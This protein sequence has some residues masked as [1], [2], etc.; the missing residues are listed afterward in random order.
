M[1]RTRSQQAR[2][3]FREWSRDSGFLVRM[4]DQGRPT[5]LDP[6]AFG[7]R[8]RDRTW[9]LFA[10]DLIS[11][12]SPQFQ[13]LEVTPTLEA[14]LDQIH[15]DLRPGGTI[16]SVPLRSPVTRKVVGGLVVRPRFGWNDIGPLLQEIGW[17]AS[18][19]LLSFPLV[20]GAAK[21]V[22]PWVLAGPI[23]ERFCA[24]LDELKPG[25]RWQE[26]VRQTPRGQILWNRYQRESMIAGRYHH[27]PCR[28]PE[29]GPDLLLRGIL[30]WGI[31]LVRRSLAG[32]VSTDPIARRLAENAAELSFKVADA[33]PVIPSRPQLD[34]LLSSTGLPSSA[35][36]RGVQALGWLF[37]ER[38]LGGTAHSD[39]LA[40]SL[41]MH[42]LFER[43]VE[44]LVRQWAHE[45]GGQVRSGRTHET[46]VPIRWKRT[47]D[48][49]V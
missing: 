21:E 43:W 3:S 23:I 46:L 28:F 34:R 27:L 5:R 47:G 25:F 40:W 1:A 39:G 11:S 49:A 38:G 7:V 8:G 36:Q 22:P 29:L 2:N 45:T 20:P 13:A 19:R 12:N 37:D 35:F 16:G 17:T 48:A 4:E 10:R 26:E 31:D 15:L 32:W 18:P 6:G 42:E 14:G 30:R 41:P 44:H 33:T 9:N 24:L